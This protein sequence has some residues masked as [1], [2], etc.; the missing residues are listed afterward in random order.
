M[1]GRARLR[2]LMQQNYPRLREECAHGGLASYIK[3]VAL[4]VGFVDDE[5]D[6]YSE[7][8]SYAHSQLHV[9]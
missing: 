4:D 8:V 2:Q 7:S 6:E 5:D 9:K 1:R 3:Q